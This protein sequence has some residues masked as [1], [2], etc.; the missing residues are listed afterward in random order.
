M[1]N[2]NLFKNKLLIIDK[3]NSVLTKKD[4]TRLLL[5]IFFSLIIAAV[6]TIGITAVMP[7]VSIAAD[8]SLIETNSYYNYVF[9]LFNFQNQN[10]FVMI[11]GI[12]LV[13]FYIF[14]SF[15]N[16]FYIYS[17]NKFSQDKVHSIGAEP[18]SETCD[19]FR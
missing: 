18:K 16:L 11:F 12:T 3:L 13:F 5:L 8:F 6:E 1:F 7:F 19:A 4:R 9:R 2:L 10:N 15:I 14:R 17:I